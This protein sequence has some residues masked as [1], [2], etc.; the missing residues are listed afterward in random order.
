MLAV[1]VGQT[2]PCAR[3]V[4]EHRGQ[5]Q[6]EWSAAPSPLTPGVSCGSSSAS[7]SGTTGTAYTS[8]SQRPKSIV[9][10]R[11]LQNGSAGDVA[12]SNSRLQTGQRICNRRVSQTRKFKSPWVARSE[13]P[14]M[15]V[16]LTMT[17]TTPFARGSGT[18]HPKFVYGYSYLK[19]FSAAPHHPII[20]PRLHPWIPR[21]ITGGQHGER[22]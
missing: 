13:L 5:R 19:R 2:F 12:V 3:A 9:R 7:G 14:A 17:K 10:H 1:P 8:P 18:C 22:Q 20:Q 6:S 21:R 15:G 11:S 4:T 16:V